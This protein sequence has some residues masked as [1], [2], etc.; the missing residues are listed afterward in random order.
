MV[1]AGCSLVFSLFSLTHRGVSLHRVRHTFAGRAGGGSEGR[2][3]S[4]TGDRRPNTSRPSTALV[5]QGRRIR[6]TAA[7]T[8]TM[9]IGAK[10]CRAGGE[11]EILALIDLIYAAA[12][13]PAGWPAFLEQL[14]RTS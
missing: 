7:L 3:S 13:D 10:A 1:T 9:A 4:S 6:L 2:P 8:K 11:S 14:A 12:T 5:A